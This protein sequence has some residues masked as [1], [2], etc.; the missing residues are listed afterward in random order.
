[1]ITSWKSNYWNTISEWKHHSAS[2]NRQSNNT[3][4]WEK[5]YVGPQPDD[6]KSSE[7]LSLSVLIDCSG[8]LIFSNQRNLDSHFSGQCCVDVTLKS[9]E[10]GTYSWSILDQTL[11]YSWAILGLSM[12]NSKAVLALSLQFAFCRPAILVKLFQFLRGPNWR[13]SVIFELF[14]FAGL[15]IFHAQF[16]L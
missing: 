15:P 9:Q 12:E 1:M 6:T 10:S 2:Q 7:D 13:L 5:K 4:C 8:P 16:S 14:Y 3:G 11:H